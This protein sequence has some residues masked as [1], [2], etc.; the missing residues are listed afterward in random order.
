M[1][2]E[3]FVITHPDRIVF[4]EGGL[5]KQDVA[6]YYVAVAPWLLAQVG[7][8][9]LSI[10][11]CPQGVGD[12]CFFQ[13]HSSEGIG[14]HVR[15]VSISEKSGRHHY[16]CIDDAEGLL[17][18]VQMNA[19]EFHPWGA[20]SDDPERADR[21]VFDLDPGPLVQW[22]EVKRAA[23]RLR[24]QLE[25]IELQSF[26]RTTGGKGLHLVVPLAPAAPWSEVKAFARAIAE[27]MVV[28]NPDRF[29]S[30][31]DKSQREGRIFIDWLRNTHGATSI[32]SYSLRARPTAGV[33]MPLAWDDLWRVR[34]PDRFTLKNALAWIEKRDADPWKGIDALGQSLPVIP[35]A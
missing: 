11:R 8:R 5:T 12:G 10:V 31:A 2:R 1:T 15:T 29:V 30:V 26:L 17:E 32:A 20:R 35:P 3:N 19:L 23:R 18:L 16:L 24:L 22:G 6:D 4:S 7:G 34:K 9:P 33:A 14:R 13:K 28:K 27:A 21:I 25:S